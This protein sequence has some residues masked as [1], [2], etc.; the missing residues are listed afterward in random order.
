MY[1]TLCILVVER[2][3]AMKKVYSI[4]LALVLMLTGILSGADKVK[5]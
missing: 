3:H 1:T 5:R 2:K 4:P